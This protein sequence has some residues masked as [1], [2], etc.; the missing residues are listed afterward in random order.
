MRD[1]REYEDDSTSDQ[2]DAVS[3][4]DIDSDDDSTRSGMAFVLALLFLGLLIAL[5]L[6]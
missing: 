5:F 6:L 1:L 3:I 4:T 2:T